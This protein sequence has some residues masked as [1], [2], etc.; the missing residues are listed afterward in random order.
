MFISNVSKVECACLCVVS[1]R[2]KKDGKIQWARSVGQHWWTQ[3]HQIKL[4][5]PVEL[6][7]KSLKNGTSGQPVISGLRALERSNQKLQEENWNPNE[8]VHLKPG[9]SLKFFLLLEDFST[10]E[11]IQR[12]SNSRIASRQYKQAHLWKQGCQWMS[13]TSTEAASC[14]CLSELQE[15]VLYRYTPLTTT[16]SG[17]ELEGFY[18][19]AGNQ[20][21]KADP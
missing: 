11:R 7:S 10:K 4:L 9:R 12:R 3:K 21:Q 16:L 5:E 20:T 13:T 17:W 8:K 15:T 6:H 19:I 18:L 1:M 14:S 2:K